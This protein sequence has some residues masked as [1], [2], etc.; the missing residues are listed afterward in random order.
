M[1]H[2]RKRMLE[3]MQLKGF[4]ERTQECYIRSVRMLA[5]H[6]NKPPD[7]ITEEQLRQYFL[8]IKNVKKWKRAT[9]T[10]ALCGIKFFFV[11]TLRKQWTTFDLVRPQREKRLPV[12]L[13]R[14]EIQRILAGV[15]FPC[16]R[17]CLLTIYSCGLRLL[18][19]CTLKVSH[20]HS[21]RMVI[22][23]EQGKGGKDRY[24]PLPKRTLI[25]LRNW[26]KIH[27]NPTWL[28]PAGGRGRHSEFMTSTLP[29]GKTNIQDAFRE[30]LRKS[31]VNKRASVRTLRHSYA[32]HLVELGVNL[33]LIQEYLGHM[34]PKTTAIYAHLTDVA[35]NQANI[36]I[37]RF[38]DDL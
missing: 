26:Y 9:V 23:V 14:N 16:Y 34:S 30:A 2:L 6:Y 11:Q 10:I 32:T 20:I 22:H 33:R 36:I 37:N 21:Q 24:V 38:M 8:H 31:G 27:H 5:Q 3:D 7:Q 19:G 29:T 25:E 15:R 12:V 18:E 13:T 28:F 4:S 17:V 35:H 1:T